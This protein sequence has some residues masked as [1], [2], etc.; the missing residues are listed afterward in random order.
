MGIIHGGRIPGRGNSHLV[1]RSGRRC[2]SRRRSAV[3]GVSQ[4]RHSRRAEK[5]RA[6]R[7]GAPPGSD[8]MTARAP[9]RPWGGG[10]ACQVAT[11]S[12]TAGGGT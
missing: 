9:R 7:D 8:A 4:A 12:G 1:M 10:S 6:R 3:A 11:A 2:F 5:A